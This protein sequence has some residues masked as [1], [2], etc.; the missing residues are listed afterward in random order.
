MV[1]PDL[2]RDTI[3]P[4]WQD[5]EET[6]VLRHQSLHMEECFNILVS[7]CRNILLLEEFIMFI[8]VGLIMLVGQSTST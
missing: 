1:V 3:T 8:M 7:V 6:L 5:E 2:L 4:I